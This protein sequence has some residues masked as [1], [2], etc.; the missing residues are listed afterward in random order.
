MQRCLPLCHVR[1]MQS[2]LRADVLSY[3]LTGLTPDGSPLASLVRS[4][5]DIYA[6]ELDLP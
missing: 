5:S 1:T 6:L 2:A 3:S 4:N